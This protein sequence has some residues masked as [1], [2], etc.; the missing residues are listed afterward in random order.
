[1]ER[2]QEMAVSVHPES[3]WI[4]LIRRPCK[5]PTFL[6]VGILCSNRVDLDFIFQVKIFAILSY[7]EFSFLL[8]S[9]KWGF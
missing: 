5:I 7:M 1:L 8:S 4:P 6:E 2:P 3:F 9:N